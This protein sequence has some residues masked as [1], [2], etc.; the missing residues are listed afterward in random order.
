MKI[1]SPEYSID[2]LID[3]HYEKN[4]ELPR[5]HMGCSMLGHPC[6]RWLWLSFRWAVIEQFPGRILR[7]F[8]RGQMEE[9]TV[10]ENLRN[11]G[12][13]IHFTG[14]NQ[15]SVN[16]GN[17]VGG[18]LDG[19][20]VSGVPGAT[21]TK[22]V[23][24]IKT[25]SLKSFNDLV[26]NGVK[27]SKPMHYIQMQQYML[28]KGLSDA[29]Y[30]AVCKDDDRLYFERVKFDGETGQAAIDRGH[31][32]VSSDRMPPP[33]STDPTWFECRFCPAHEFCH[34]T[35][36]TKQVN[37]RT[38]AHSTA[39]P[40]STWHC[41]EYDATIP[42]V[43]AQRAGCSGH[44]IHPDLTPWTTE[45]DGKNV[46]WI[47]PYGK[48][49]NGNA[50]LGVFESLEILANPEAC[51]NPDKFIDEVRDIFGGKVVE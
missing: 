38:C 42:D 22:H 10:I 2:A 19:I 39:K 31:R 30:V 23:L 9:A 18:S 32:I 27:K 3:K 20:A 44:I 28:G 40:D 33:L 25:H 11:I 34:K 12:V 6:D 16:F 17:H 45:F 51:A 15:T 13:E 37:C 14:E 5:A 48:I 35:K 46:I 47:T 24:E 49:K 4:Q 36:L 29:L 21:K 1:P 43:A 41:A 50:S 7:L 26:K 8:K